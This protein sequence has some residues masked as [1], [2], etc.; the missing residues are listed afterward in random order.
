[1]R[2]HHKKGMNVLHKNFNP[3]N[4][5]VKIIEK[6][7]KIEILKALATLYTRTKI[8]RRFSA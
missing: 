5:I 2:I 7:V 6:S 1:M 3:L 8:A 4:S